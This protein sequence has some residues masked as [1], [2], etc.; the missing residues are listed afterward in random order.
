MNPSP[1]QRPLTNPNLSLNEPH[2]ASRDIHD[3]GQGN[4][5]LSRH[6]VFCVDEEDGDSD[7]KIQAT[8]LW[9]AYVHFGI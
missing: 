4:D 7:R 1:D 5:R 8:P 3:K 9:V 2:L 6:A